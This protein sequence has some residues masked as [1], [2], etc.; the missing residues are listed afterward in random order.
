MDL[1]NLYKT[2]QIDA[3]LASS[4]YI[5]IR[6]FQPRKH[7]RSHSINNVNQPRRK[8]VEITILLNE[9]EFSYIETPAEPNVN[10]I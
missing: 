7:S 3:Y 1:E 8:E 6:T 10:L 4:I 9:K 5:Q 2:S